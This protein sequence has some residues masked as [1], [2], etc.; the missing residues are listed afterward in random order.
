MTKIVL[1]TLPAAPDNGNA[2]PDEHEPGP[3]Y[4]ARLRN[5]FQDASGQALISLEDAMGA[6][7]EIEQL[8]AVFRIMV[9]RTN[10][11]IPRCARPHPGNST[12]GAVAH[13]DL[14]RK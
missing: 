2:D 14:P 7:A 3:D 1:G 8:W 12:P 6:A 5:A 4:A 10:A 11:N 9:G 13:P